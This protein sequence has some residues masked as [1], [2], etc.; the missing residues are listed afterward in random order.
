LNISSIGLVEMTRQRMRRSIE[1]SSYEKC[2]YCNGRGAIK[3]APT[4]SI[5][6]ARKLERFLAQARAREVFISLHPDV[7]AYISDPQRR[8]INAL[9]R[10]FR[11]RIRV[12]EDKNLHM[13]EI[14]IEGSK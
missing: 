6:A 9:E 1:G 10:R 14:K 8:I 4:V 7:S 12:L 11:V 2:P 3:S 5:G 13:E